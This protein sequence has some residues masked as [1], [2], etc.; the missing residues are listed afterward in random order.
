MTDYFDLGTYSHEISTQSGQAQ[1]WFDRGLIW[2]YGFNQ[3]EACRCFEQVIV[4]DPQCAMG[5]WGIAYALGP[6]YNKPWEWYGDEERILALKIC[7]ENIQKAQE[8]A[9]NASLLEQQLIESLC[10]KFQSAE[11]TDCDT[12]N[13][14][15]HD[16]ANSMAGVLA[17]FPQDL[18]TICLSAEAVMNLTPWKLWDLRRGL[19]AVGALT[20]RAIEILTQGMA[21]TELV[22]KEPHPGILH[23]YIHLLEMSPFPD[24]ALKAANQ[25]RHLCPQAGHLLHM[26]THI[27]VLCGHYLEAVEASNRAIEADMEYLTLRGKHEF[28]LISCL[29]NYHTKIYAAMFLGQFDTAMEAAKGLRSIVTDD[30]LKINERYLASTLE[31]YYSSKVHVLVRFGR[32]Q[33]IL[34]EPLPEDQALY[35]M[36]TVLLYYGKGVAHSALGDIDQARQ[37]QATFEQLCQAIPDWHSVANNPTPDILRVASAMLAGELDYH[38]GNHELGYSNLREASELSDNLSYSEPWPWMHP[39]R[40]ALGALLLEQDHVEE[41]MQHY[42]DD[43]GIDDILPRCL[44]HPNNIW[45]LHGY[46]ECLNRTGRLEEAAALKPQLDAAMALVD[47]KIES[48]CCCRKKT[49][50]TG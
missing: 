30:L 24:K 46:Y 44:Q 38:A 18:E 34:D 35:P 32:W 43:L 3:E 17:R 8:M 27:D 50:D 4:H 36:T 7:F 41:A 45:A 20:E 5:Y 1:I 42:R 9:P 25:L 22:D 49:F 26:S 10:L 33:D 16:Y 6:F 31:A 29:H 2:C 40:H 11:V 13:Q 28:Y 12:M 19:P 23:F 21:L 37:C 14:W 48:S 15:N 47:I 39:P